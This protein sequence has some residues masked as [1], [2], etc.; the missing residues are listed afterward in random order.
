MNIYFKIYLDISRY[1]QMKD[2]DMHVLVHVA[3]VYLALPEACLGFRRL[4]PRSMTRELKR[5]TTI[6]LRFESF[7]V[8]LWTVSSPGS[9]AFYWSKK[10]HQGGYS[11]SGEEK[12]CSSLTFDLSVWDVDFVLWYNQ[13]YRRL[14]SFE[15]ILLV[16]LDGFNG[17]S[18]S[19]AQI[20]HCNWRLHLELALRIPWRMFPHDRAESSQKKPR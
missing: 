8:L 14:I 17:I 1:L 13:P 6:I 12:L 15:K 5:P 16:H 9:N 11:Y 3:F 7:S 4:S 2:G 19:K 18:T 10:I 20:D